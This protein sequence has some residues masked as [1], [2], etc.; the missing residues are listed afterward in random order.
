[1]KMRLAVVATHPIQYHSPVFRELSSREDVDIRVFYGWEGTANSIDHGFGKK[2]A[3]DIPLLDGYQ[4]EMVPNVAKEPGTHHYAGIDLPELNAR[5]TGWKADAVLVYGWNYKAHLAAIRHF[6]GKIPVLFRG[7]STLLNEA[8]GFRKLLR[9]F[10]LKRVYKNIDFALAVGTNNRRYFEALGLQPE[11]IVFAPHAIENE[12]FSV[13]RDSSQ[14][15][16]DQWRLSLGI[17]QD[18]IVFL[19]VGK[20]ETI[21]S[22]DVLLENF[23]RLNRPD[24]RLVFVGSGPME[25]ELQSKANSQVHF[26]GFQNQSRLPVA[27]RLGD[28]VVLCSRSETWGLALNEAM[29]CE[30]AIIASDRVGSAIDLIEPGKNGWI[31]TYNNVNSLFDVM[32]NAAS[33]SRMQL[34]EMGRYSQEKI[35]SWSIANQVDAIIRCLASI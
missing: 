6:K 14:I 22:L 24:I 30:R 29:A 27:Y 12:R 7:D 3:W 23:L 16:A 10:Y 25:S 8:P 19:Y 2:V 32:N 11:Q 13:G 18:S 35:Q 20:L 15:A 21:K 4:W 34:S 28:V 31:S 26:L 5:V 33:C 9:R 1:M 17:P